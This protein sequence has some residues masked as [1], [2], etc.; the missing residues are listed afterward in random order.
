MEFLMATV[1]IKIPQHSGYR[2]GSKTNDRS[3]STSN[4]NSRRPSKRRRSRHEWLR[5]RI[6]D[7]LFVLE[8]ATV[9]SFFGFALYKLGVFAFLITSAIY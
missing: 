8:V 5:R 3:R 2:S 6:E 1:E 9:V 4:S 7:G